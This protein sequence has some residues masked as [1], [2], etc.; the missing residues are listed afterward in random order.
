MAPEQL[1]GKEADARTDLWALGAMLYEMVTGR[2]AF[3]GE[4]AGE[5]HRQHHERRA[6]GARDAAAADAAFARSRRQEVPRQAARRPMGHRARRGGRTAVDRADEHSGASA[7]GQARRPRA[8][9][10]TGIAVGLVA[11]AIMGVV[12]GWLA[13]RSAPH[14]PLTVTRS[15]VDVLPADELYAYGANPVIV[16]TPGGSRTALAWTPDGQALVFVGRRRGVQQ[17]YV[18]R[19]D[20][21][22]ARPLAGTDGAVLPAVSPDG[23]WV[24]FWAGGAIR[25]IPLSGG[26]VDEPRT[27]LRVPPRGLAWDDGGRVYFGR[28]RRRPHLADSDRGGAVGSDD[29]GG[30]G[31]RTPASLPAPRREGVALHRRGNA[32][33]RGVTSPLSRRRLR[34]E[35]AR[36]CSEMRR[37]RGTCLPDISCS[38]G[39]ARCSPSGSTPSDWR[40]R[41]RRWPCSI[42]SRRH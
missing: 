27:G 26:P 4:S 39:G 37:T 2:R 38:F 15:L 20:A 40:S 8:W 32:T 30:A 42:P 5:P 14:R 22:E 25:K 35:S 23:Q 3:E 13:G 10:A 6:A 34:R 36:S 31:C 41:A 9:L 12:A 17:I 11:V 33:G 28:E 24:A 21:S 7:A 16:F 19:L 18:R 29:P 1:E